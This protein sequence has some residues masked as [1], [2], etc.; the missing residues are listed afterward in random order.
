MKFQSSNKLIS[1]STTHGNLKLVHDLTPCQRRSRASVS[2]VAKTYVTAE[3]P[4]ALH[5]SKFNATDTHENEIPLN[6]K[7]LPSKLNSEAPMVI[8]LDESLEL[9][10]LDTSTSAAITTTNVTQCSIKYNLLE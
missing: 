9:S 7:A 2:S 10:S 8:D 4:L 3:C 6:N 5:L 1:S